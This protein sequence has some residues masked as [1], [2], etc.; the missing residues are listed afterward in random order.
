MM[1]PS[2]ASLVL[3]DVEGHQG[4]PYRHP[5]GVFDELLIPTLSATDEGVV[6]DHE[7]TSL[8]AFPELNE[9]L[10]LC[11]K[12]GRRVSPWADLLLDRPIPEAYSVYLDIVA[13]TPHTDKHAVQA[14][15]T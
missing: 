1:L 6:S 2:G 12:M 3:K 15:F 4:G 13:P 14:L 11:H 8:G 9:R 10:Y 7:V 5:S